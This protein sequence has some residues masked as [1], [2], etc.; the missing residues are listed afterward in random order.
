MVQSDVTLSLSCVVSVGVVC[1]STF[2]YNLGLLP[3]Y[4]ASPIPVWQGIMNNRTWLLRLFFSFFQPKGTTFLTDYFLVQANISACEY[5]VSDSNQ[6]TVCELQRWQCC[7]AS[8]L[9]SRRNLC[10]QLKSHMWLFSLFAMAACKGLK[11]AWLLYQY[12]IP[13]QNV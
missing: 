12:Y 13:H 1:I 6:N 11:L 2:Q 9:Q 7:L 8:P 5:L 10:N 4:P 3:H